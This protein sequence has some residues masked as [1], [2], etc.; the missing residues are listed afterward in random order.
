VEYNLKG[1]NQVQIKEEIGR[2]FA[3]VLRSFL[4]QDPDVILVGEVRD[5]ET[6]QIAIRA[7]LTGH[8]VLS[9]LHT[10][11][12]PSTIARLGDM[13]IPSFLIAAS[14]LLI[15]AQRLCR[16]VCPDCKESY[17]VDA[18][19]LAI[20]GYIP[21]G[22]G[23][24]TCYKG[25]GCTACNYTGMRGR[26]AIYEVM[27]ASPEIRDLIL[28]AAPAS[29]IKTMATAQGMKTLRQAGLQKVV[30]GTTTLEEILRVTFG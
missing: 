8:L 1:I 26:M 9:T 29:E 21:E 15:M 25:K 11:D 2:T 18:E 14:V 22:P 10:N 28:R 16:K 12:A 13:G 6:A 23:P 5:L 17:L 7:A 3:G 24:V 19:A 4:R 27:P 20:H 30:E